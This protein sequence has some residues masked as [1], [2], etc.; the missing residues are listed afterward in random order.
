M[1]ILLLDIDIIIFFAH[2]QFAHSMNQLRV[3][4]GS[5]LKIWGNFYKTIFAMKYLKHEVK[6]TK[7]SFSFQICSKLNFVPAQFLAH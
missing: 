1:L 6:Y 7:I 3:N 4:S 2:I 5:L